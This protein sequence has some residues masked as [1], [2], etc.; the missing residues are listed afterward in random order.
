MDLHAIANPSR[1]L[2][3]SV[4]LESRGLL[5]DPCVVQI[6]SL[7]RFFLHQVRLDLGSEL[8]CTFFLGGEGKIDTY[9]LILQ[10]KHKN[11]MNF[12]GPVDTLCCCWP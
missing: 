1:K 12:G 10:K 8:Y 4:V 2:D 11:W 7:D 3:F 9:L 6:Q 5:W